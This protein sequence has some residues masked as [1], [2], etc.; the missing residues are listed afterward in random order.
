MPG[1]LGNDPLDTRSGDGDGVVEGQRPVE[2]AAS[3]LAAIGHLAQRRSVQRGRHRRADR[4]DRGQ[5]RDLGFAH[6]DHLR[7]LDGV[8]DDVC[9]LFQSRGDIDR[10]IGDD[11]RARI[12][13]CLQQEAMADPALG[14]QPR[15]CRNQRGHQFVGVQAP[16][17][18]GFDFTCGCQGDGLLRSGVA[19]R[20]VHNGD[21]GQIQPGLGGDCFEPPSWPDQHRLDQ[22]RVARF[23]RSGQA[24]DIA[25]M[26]DGYPNR[27]QVRDMRQQ[28]LQACAA[29]R[30]RMDFRQR[31]ARS[32]NALSGR[33]DLY[34]AL[35][36]RHPLLAGAG[37]VQ[38]DVMG[39]RVFAAHLH[40]HGQPVAGP[41]GSE[42]AQVLADILGSRPRQACSQHSRDQDVCTNGLR[43]VPR[44]R[45]HRRFRIH[46]A[47]LQ[48]E[49]VDVLRR[50]RAFEA[51]AVA[52]GDLVEGAVAQNLQCVGGAIDRCGGRRHL[53][54]P[55][56]V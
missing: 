50:K 11:E 35:E 31:R 36:N 56:R 44:G 43:G 22:P 47:R 3:D 34:L 52:D 15:C 28:V 54:F 24:G 38:R 17:H 27:L 9:L 29:L 21:V 41:N 33:Y 23:E 2:Q 39:G 16:F 42:Q 5:D 46:I 8:A 55:R 37:A 48:R 4:L 20:D 7:Q 12:G 51:G 26:G 13:R 53:P 30:I 49:H 25:R 40:L 10:R 45:R 1:D 6:A 32:F 14:A 19:V 18:Q